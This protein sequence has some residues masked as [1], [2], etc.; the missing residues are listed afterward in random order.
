MLALKTWT[1]SLRASLSTNVTYS[2][3][4]IVAPAWR[5]IHKQHALEP[6]LVRVEHDLLAD[7]A[8]RIEG[9]GDLELAPYARA[10]VDGSLFV[11]GGECAARAINH[12]DYVH[13]P[14]LALAGETCFIAGT[15]RAG[16]P[17]I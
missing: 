1:E 5:H 6:V 13:Y 7:G 10:V 4:D 3:H 2:R 11:A 9:D 17:G 8:T 14:R 15:S 16:S 12:E